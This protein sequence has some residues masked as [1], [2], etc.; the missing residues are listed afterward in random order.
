ME[1]VTPVV[2]FKIE[3][4]LG[5]EGLDGAGCVRVQ[6]GAGAELWFSFWPATYRHSDWEPYDQPALALY[7]PY[8]FKE[9]DQVPCGTAGKFLVSRVAPRGGFKPTPE[10]LEQVLAAVALIVPA[11]HAAACIN[12]VRKRL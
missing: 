11:E 3:Q 10:Q 5:W 12:A 6:W 2:E 8:S 1:P 9:C 4:H 7:I